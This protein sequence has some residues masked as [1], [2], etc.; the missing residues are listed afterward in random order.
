MVNE[1]V[2]VKDCCKLRF[3]ASTVGKLRGL[4]RELELTE[5]PGLGSRPFEGTERGTYGAGPTERLK[6]GVM[7]FGAGMVW[8]ASTGRFGVTVWPKMEPKTPVSKLLP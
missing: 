1:R 6:A 4:G 2:G 3:Q 7:A 8:L 5:E